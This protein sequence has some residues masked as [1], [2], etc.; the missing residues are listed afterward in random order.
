MSIYRPGG[1]ELTRYALQKIDVN[2]G[3]HLLDIGCGDGSAALCA[4]REFGLKVTAIDRDERAVCE[5]RSRG[6]D[7]RVMD[8]ETMDISGMYFD[9]IL[10]ECVLSLVAQRE[11]VLQRACSM[12]RPSG[13]LVISDVYQ[14]ASS[15]RND[16]CTEGTRI[17]PEPLKVLLESM[18][19]E[20]VLCEDRTKDLKT[21]LAQAILSYG[22]LDAWFEAEGG[23]SPCSCQYGKGTGYVLLAFRR[24]HA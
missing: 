13:H 20:L 10:M 7:A 24:N 23:W 8:A 5:A 15:T 3:E 22:S 2:P 6:V 16:S 19:M 17:Q 21:F 11:S 18:G 9:T 1:L 12:L 14:K 4:M